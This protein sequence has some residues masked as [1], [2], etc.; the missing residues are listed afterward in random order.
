MKDAV[1]GDVV[2]ETERGLKRRR[3][4]ERA[5]A[6][7]LHSVTSATS[8]TPAPPRGSKTRE[9]CSNQGALLSVYRK[10]FKMLKP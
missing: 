3:Q 5:S 2:A 6:V 8:A 10:V 4:E 7:Q 1:N 9:R